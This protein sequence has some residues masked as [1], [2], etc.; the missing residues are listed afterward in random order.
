M[1]MHDKQ[2]DPPLPATVTFVIGLGVLFVIGWL[3][4]FRLLTVRW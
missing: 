1:P 4:M 3:L 2:K